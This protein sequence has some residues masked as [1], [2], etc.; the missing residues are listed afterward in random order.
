MNLWQKDLYQIKTLYCVNSRQIK[1]PVW[2]KD[3][4]EQYREYAT[5]YPPTAGELNGGFKE[6]LLSRVKNKEAL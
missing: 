4:E 3:L 2:L 1:P 5:M 6:R